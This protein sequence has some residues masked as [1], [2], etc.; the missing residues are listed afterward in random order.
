MKAIYQKPVTD[1]TEIRAQQAIL[2][3]SVPY[4]NDEV[5]A[6]LGESRGRSFFDDDEEY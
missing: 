3:D 2:A 5:N 6:G 4:N 1:I